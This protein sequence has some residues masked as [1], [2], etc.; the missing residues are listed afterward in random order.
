MTIATKLVNAGKKTSAPHIICKAFA[1]TGKSTMLVGGIQHLKGIKPHVMVDIDPNNPGRGKRKLDIIP[2]PQQAAVWKEMA[3]G[4]HDSIAFVAFSKAIAMALEKRIPKGKNCQAMTMH[5][6][7]GRIVRNHF[8]LKPGLGATNGWRTSNIICEVSKTDIWTLKKKHGD[9]L[10]A[11]EKLVGLCKVNLAEPTEYNLNA[12][13]S[14]YDVDLNGSRNRV[15][16]TVPDVLERC[17]DVSKDMEM[18]YN[19]MI[20]LPIVHDL[21]FKPFDLLLWDESQDGNRC[22]QALARKCGQRLLLCGD[23]FQAIYGFAGADSEAMDR[24]EEDLGGPTGKNVIVLPLT[25]TRRCGKAIVKE[26]QFRVPEF[27][28]HEDN[29]DGTVLHRSFPP[30]SKD[31]YRELVTPGD[32]ILCRCNAPLISECFRF[33]RK[34]QK[35]NI[36]GRDVGQGL[37]ALIKRVYKNDARKAGVMNAKEWAKYYP[38]IGVE[39][40]R[41]RLTEWGIAEVAREQ[42]GRNPSDIKIANIQDKVDCLLFFAEDAKTAADVVD[43]VNHIFTD[44][45]VDGILLSSIHKAKGLEAQRVFLIE[46]KGATVPHPMATKPWERE[47]EK[48]LRYVAITRAISE[49]VYVSE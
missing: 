1:G 16:D 46:P 8:K 13:C 37:I 12:L 41:W 14:H 24:M 3:K 28:A 6:M 35:A 45:K 22:Q 49:L 2:S 30:E 23:E 38:S 10:N 31:D 44:D 7:G 4:N 11:T 21:A 32:M 27:E 43:E 48:N 5:R 20:W 18:D 17:K 39:D 26:A 34:G 19:D 47:Q 42:K 36:Q 25:V 40:L 9:F 29:P 15:Y 33:L